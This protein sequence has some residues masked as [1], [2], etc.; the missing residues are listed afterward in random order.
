MRLIVDNREPKDMILELQNRVTN[1]SLENLE[2]G[3]FIIKNNK[4][5]TILLFERKSLADLISSIKDGRYNEQSFRLSQCELDNKYIYYIIEGNILNFCNKEN[6]TAKKML[7]SS[8]LSLSYKKGFSILHTTSQVETIEYIVRF[9]DKL[10]SESEK[11]EK[12]EKSENTIT[13]QSPENTY[14]NVVKTSKKSNITTENIN[15]IMLIQIPG[16]SIQVAKSLMVKFKTIIE[17]TNALKE[18]NKCLDSIIIDYEG[19][20]RKLSKSV[21]KNLLTFLQVTK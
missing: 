11:S 4:D 9:Y 2:L 21:I 14:S 12:S 19:G 5:E 1:V 16:I 6:E 7:F 20:K 13:S 10:K 18:N 17:L 3:D 8:M 15:E